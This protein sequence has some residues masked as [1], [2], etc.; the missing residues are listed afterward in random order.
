MDVV[1]VAR[2]CHC[3]RA[4]VH[5]SLRVHTM[6][7][8]HATCARCTCVTCVA[9]MQRMHTVAGIHSH[10]SSS[11]LSDNMFQQSRGIV[12]HVFMLS[13]TL[14][15][16]SPEHWSTVKARHFRPEHVPEL[17]TVFVRVWNRFRRKWAWAFCPNIVRQPAICK[18]KCHCQRVRSCAVFCD[19]RKSQ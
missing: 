17:L 1:P 8:I 3:A 13:S 2:L 9:S 6:R 11:Y 4:T 14:T 5:V 16:T 15:P 18:V 7:C 10:S 19:V 12:C